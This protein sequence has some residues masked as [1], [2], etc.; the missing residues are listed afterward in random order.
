[1]L[2]PSWLGTRCRHPPAAL[3]TAC[4]PAPPPHPPP[5]SDALEFGQYDSNGGLDYHLPVEGSGEGG[6][7][8][9]WRG[10]SRPARRLADAA[11][12]ERAGSAGACHT[13]WRKASWLNCFALP[14]CLCAVVEE[15]PLHVVHVAVEM[16]PIC[17][18]GPRPLLLCSS[19]CCVGPKSSRHAAALPAARRP[20]R[21]CFAAASRAL[22]PPH[23]WGAARCPQVGGLGDV[24]TALGRAVQEQGHMVEVILPRWV[25]WGGR[26]RAGMA[27]AAGHLGAAAV[28][29]VQWTTALAAARGASSAAAPL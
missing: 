27:P 14:P 5:R 18:V 8:Q 10:C 12:G 6:A 13:R 16:A 28:A 17:K 1:M 20:L 25:G 2:P 15:P 4:S 24:V 7:G 3:R 11:G 19:W 21:C 22:N 9:R 26:G 29:T 23:P